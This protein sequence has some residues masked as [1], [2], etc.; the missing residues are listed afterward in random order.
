M[1]L[2]LAIVWA[3]RKGVEYDSY[4]SIKKMLFLILKSVFFC[5]TFFPFLIL[6]RR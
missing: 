2:L 4:L 6:H 5:I 3:A 1:R